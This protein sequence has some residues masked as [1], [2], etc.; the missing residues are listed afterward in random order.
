[1]ESR[2]PKTEL[3][4]YNH[5]NCQEIMKTSLNQWQ[6]EW[7]RYT[8]ETKSNT[9]VNDWIGTGK[10]CRKRKVKDDSW[11]AGLGDL[12]LGAW[13]NYYAINRSRERYEKSGKDGEMLGR[14][15][16]MRCKLVKSEWNTPMKRSKRHPSPETR[17]GPRIRCIIKPR[18]I[19]DKFTIS[20]YKRMIRFIEVSQHSRIY[21]ESIKMICIIEKYLKNQIIR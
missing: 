9:S 16:E 11:V 2:N 7:R 21:Y 1:M 12:A 18:P 4:V 14:N 17:E 8:W 10:D 13:A 3:W 5:F 15:N 20:V 6:V 19:N